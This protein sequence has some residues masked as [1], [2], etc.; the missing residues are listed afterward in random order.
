MMQPEFQRSAEVLKTA[1][2]NDTILPAIQW[3]Q[4]ETTSRIWYN[5]FRPI[6]YSGSSRRKAV[7]YNKRRNNGVIQNSNVSAE[8]QKNTAEK[9]DT[10]RPAKQWDNLRPSHRDDPTASAQ[11]IHRQ[12]P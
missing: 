5:S 9:G 3:D 2:K 10:M 7:P 12:R 11:L 6:E 4:L 8:V 1:A